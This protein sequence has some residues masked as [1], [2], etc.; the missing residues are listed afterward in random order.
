MIDGPHSVVTTV[1]SSQTT[2]FFDHEAAAILITSGEPAGIGPDIVLKYFSTV[3]TANPL[4]NSFI[5]LGDPTVFS[6]RARLLGLDCQIRCI[7]HPRD[8]PKAIEPGTLY[9]W[10]VNVAEPVQAGT[11]NPANSA[12]VLEMLDKAVAACMSGDA[13]AIVTAPVHKG[14]INDAGILFTGHTEYLQVKTHTSRVVMLL[15]N[16][17]MANEALRV[18]LVT[19]H[20]PLSKVASSLSIENITAV[21]EVVNQGLKQDFGIVQPRIAVCGLNPHAGEGGYLGHEEKEIIEPA[22]NRLKEK[23]I[24]VSGPWAADTI[25]VPRHAQHFDVIVAMYHDQGL[26]AFKQASFGDG[27][28]V[29]LGLPLIRTSVDHGTALALAGTGEAD[30]SSLGSAHQLAEQLVRHRYA[31]SSPSA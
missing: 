4:A 8:K 28:N 5:V 3:A 1:S 2:P 24:N 26:A 11:L 15:A 19:V 21:I 27:V 16:E 17:H 31:A 22:L 18:A 23:G 10:P 29:T 30:A 13:A 6:E 12:Y 9:I 14:V 7:E 20:M 25:F